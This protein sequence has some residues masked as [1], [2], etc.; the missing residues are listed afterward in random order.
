MLPTAKRPDKLQAVVFASPEKHHTGIVAVRMRFS[1]SFGVVP[2]IV[3]IGFEI[4]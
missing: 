2:V 4:P 3:A 1:L